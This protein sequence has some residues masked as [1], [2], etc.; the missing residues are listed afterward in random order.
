MKYFQKKKNFQK[1][2]TLIEMLVVI[3]I[4]GIGLV[5][6]LSFFNINL[7]NQSE[8][9]NELIAAG[10]AQE[11]ADLVRNIRD[12]NTLNGNAWNLNLDAGTCLIDFNSVDSSTAS[13]RHKCS[14]AG[15]A[16]CLDTSGRYYQCANGNTIFTRTVT[17]SSVDASSMK[18][19]CKV[20]WN[21]GSRTTSA[22]N[23]IYNNSF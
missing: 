9:K 3:V 6:A 5:G 19:E 18:I 10:L 7:S 11:G 4:V 21:N 1:G 14:G 8:G 12:Y 17:I 16:V 2:F 15:P 20:V 23:Y 13:V 22:V